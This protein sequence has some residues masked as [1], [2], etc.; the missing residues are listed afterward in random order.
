MNSTITVALNREAEEYLA[1]VVQRYLEQRK[2]NRKS[3]CIKKCEWVSRYEDSP[4]GFVDIEIGGYKEQ[5]PLA[6]PASIHKESGYVYI[7]TD[8][9]AVKIGQTKNLKSRISSIQTG[10]PRQIKVLQTIKV[11]DMDSVEQ[12]I[13]YHYRDYHKRDEWFDLL[14]VFGV[15][16]ASEH[17]TITARISEGVSA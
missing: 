16:A 11:Q 1:S 3:R 4:H 2:S 15:S 17:K 14:P 12:S 8:G 9:E 5:I 10:N 7:I 13:H 6:P